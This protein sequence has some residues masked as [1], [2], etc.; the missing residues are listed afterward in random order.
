LKRRIESDAILKARCYEMIE[1]FENKGGKDWSGVFY[2][3][4]EFME[5]G[6][7]LT[8]YIKM[9][10]EDPASVQWEQRVHFAEVMMSAIVRLHEANIVHTDLKPD[11]FFMIPD[12]SNAGFKLKLIDLDFSIMSDRQAPWHG[13]N[14]YV[15]TP[16]YRSP[17][18]LREEVPLKA[19]DI[20]T[21]GL[22]LGELL[23]SGHPLMNEEDIENATAEG[24]FTAVKIEQPIDKVE[25]MEFLECVINSCFDPDPSKRPTARQLWNALKGDVFEWHAWQ[26]KIGDVAGHKLGALLEVT[27]GTAPYMPALKAQLSEH[28]PDAIIKEYAVSTASIAGLEIPKNPEGVLDG[29]FELCDSGCDQVFWL[30]ESPPLKPEFISRLQEMVERHQLKLNLRTVVESIPTELLAVIEASAGAFKGGDL[31]GDLTPSLDSDDIFTP[32][33]DD[34][35]SDASDNTIKF[36]KGNTDIVFL[37]DITGSMQPCI[38]FWRDNLKLLLTKLQGNDCAPYLISPASRIRFCGYRDYECDGE[39]WWVET[40]FYDIAEVDKVVD[41]LG[42]VEAKGGGDEPEC[43]LD[44]LWKITSWEATEK[45]E[46]SDPEKWRH[47][48]LA[49]RVVLLFTDATYKPTCLIPEAMGANLSDIINRIHDNR[50]MLNGFVPEGQECYYDLGEAAES[51]ICEVPLAANSGS[52]WDPVLE[53]IMPLVESYFSRFDMTKS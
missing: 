50:I 43:L 28:F 22:I 6:K 5:G 45:G 53:D 46:V 16:C 4:F 49:E 11:N 19:S 9:F 1:F 32:S 31:A 41:K 8:D 13:E 35:E 26:G 40:P 33:V 44:A 24:R 3:S 36:I 21:C 51:E 23:G 2:Q 18:H 47:R 20:Y 52:F 42:Q 27:S 25:N 17:E 34:D 7:P 15:G 10:R 29:I 48:H 38:D 30:C 12:K 14:G 37:I 39:F